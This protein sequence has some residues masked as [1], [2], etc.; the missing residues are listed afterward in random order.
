MP[1]R[2]ELWS[3]LVGWL[4]QHPERAA[5]RSQVPLRYRMLLEDSNFQEREAIKLVAHVRSLGWCLRP[6]YLERLKSLKK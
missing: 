4:E 1:E 2:L 3:G 5:H 6:D